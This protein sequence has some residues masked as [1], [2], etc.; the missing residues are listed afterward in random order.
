MMQITKSVRAIITL[1]LIILLLGCISAGAHYQ[2]LKPEQQISEIQSDLKKLG[3]Y[4]GTVDGAYGKQTST[5]IQ[6]FQRDHGMAQDGQISKSLYIQAGLAVTEQRKV[7]STNNTQTRSTTGYS[8]NQNTQSQSSES[9]GPNSCATADWTGTVR[10]V[11]DLFDC[12]TTRAIQSLSAG[13][14]VTFKVVRVSFNDSK[15]H[16]SMDVVPSYAEAAQT[17]NSKKGSFSWNNY[18]DAIQGYGSPYTVSCTFTPDKGTSLTKGAV[19]EVNAKLLNYA[20]RTLT[21]ECS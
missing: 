16:V 1:G 17:A 2:S 10:N 9:T 18:F 6:N 13:R 21:M 5:A 20:N 7:S 15:F 8:T 3:Y 4:S 14:R 19:M 12:D 11:A